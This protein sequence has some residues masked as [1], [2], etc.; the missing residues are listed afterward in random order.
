MTRYAFDLLFVLT[1]VLPAAAVV[2]GALLL[3]L[4]RHAKRPHQA[5]RAVG[6]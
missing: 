5:P 1:L 4:P 2:A 3:V 6:A